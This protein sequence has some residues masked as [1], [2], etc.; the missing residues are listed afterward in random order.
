VKWILA[1]LAAATLLAASATAFA[2]T[3]PPSLPPPSTSVVGTASAVDT[4]PMVGTSGAVAGEL[5]RP[6]TSVTGDCGTA[7]ITLF[8]SGN[9]LYA[10]WHVTSTCGPIDDYQLYV[11]FYHTS[12]SGPLID[13]IWKWGAGLSTAI[14]GQVDIA[15]PTAGTY[16]ATLTGNARTITGTDEY[17][18]VPYACSYVSAGG[19]SL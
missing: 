3:P 2:A 1:P 13:T 14:S 4:A 15:V 11:N 6:N 5:V 9:I 10:H 12:T 7:S 18:M 8:S 16:C 17:S 19:P